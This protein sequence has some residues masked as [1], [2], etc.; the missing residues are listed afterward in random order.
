MFKLGA[1]LHLRS[2]MNNF[3]LIFALSAIMATGST[4][5]GTM[6][7]VEP[8][9]SWVGTLS[10]GPVWESGGKTQTFYLASEI[11]KTYAAN[12]DTHTL[13]DGEVFLGF[14]K[15]LSQN[16]QGQLGLAIAATSNAS[17][18]GAIWDDADP[19]FANYVYEYQIQHTHI[20]AKAKLLA[21]MGYWVTP[22]ISGSLGVG[23]NYANSYS[24]TPIIFE[25]I[26]N[27]N[28]KSHTET[29][30]T[31]TVGAG[32]QKALNNHWQV[33]VGYEFADWGKSNLNRAAGQT[34][35]SG[36]SL[37]HLYTNGVMF[38]LTYLA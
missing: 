35:N 2:F 26:P 38:N 15:V 7:A 3:S 36:I 34:L 1:V 8:T 30:F 22:W 6:G 16:L 29:T 31:Y 11:E 4:S 25:A 12:S 18:S 5:A 27:E 21:D 13:F 17:L 9:G 32:V 14:Q 37:N 20:A 28:F 33:G 10:L 23:F 19:E 24:N